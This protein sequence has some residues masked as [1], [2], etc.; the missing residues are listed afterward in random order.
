[1]H[2]L[3]PSAPG[4]C[5][6][7]AASLRQL[8]RDGNENY[9]LEGIFPLGRGVVGTQGLAFSRDPEEAWESSATR[10]VN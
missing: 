4:G 10:L 9:D 7:L 2:C 1:M 3:A 5:T 8:V 6:V